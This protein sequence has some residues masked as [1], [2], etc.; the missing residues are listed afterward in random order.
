MLVSHFLKLD[1]HTKACKHTYTMHNY[2]YNV[3]KHL[4]AHR[5]TVFILKNQIPMLKTSFITFLTWVKQNSHLAMNIVVTNDVILQ[6]CTCG[7][8]CHS[9]KI[10]G[11]GTTEE[12]FIQGR[13]YRTL[14]NLLAGS[15]LPCHWQGSDQ[16]QPVSQEVKADK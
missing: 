1:T 2:I 10:I 14:C 13:I 8:S 4:D 9:K 3:R 6:K 5:Y 7:F 11:F 15:D 12:N 16:T